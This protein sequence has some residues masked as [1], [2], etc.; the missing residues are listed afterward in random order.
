MGFGGGLGE[1]QGGGR[2]PPALIEGRAAA[3]V[4]M[5]R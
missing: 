5:R 3:P 2:V 1:G 4:G